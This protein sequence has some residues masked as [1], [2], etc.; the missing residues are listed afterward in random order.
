[1]VLPQNADLTLWQEIDEKDLPEE[2][3]NG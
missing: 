1:V 2:E 3:T